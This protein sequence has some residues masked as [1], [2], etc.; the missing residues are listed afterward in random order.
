M[1]KLVASL[2]ES[3]WDEYFP[4]T[5]ADADCIAIFKDKFQNVPCNYNEKS[6]FDPTTD[7]LAY[8]CETKSITSLSN[9]ACT[10]PF[11]HQ[12]I[13]YASCAHTVVPGFNP[14]GKPWC[15]TEVSS[16]DLFTT[17]YYLINKCSVRIFLKGSFL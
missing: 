16:M 5:D 10:F 8:I 7:G 13:E 9:E 14:L 15:G 2:I 12:G 6:G 17:L 3:K 11:V 1:D 4:T